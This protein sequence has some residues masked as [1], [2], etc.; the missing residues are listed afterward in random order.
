LYD[1]DVK[2]GAA[3]A[4][5]QIKIKSSVDKA[6]WTKSF[7]QYKAATVELKRAKTPVNQF[8]QSPRR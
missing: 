6:F 3:F 8:F 7:L 2:F 1:G 5:N 4:R